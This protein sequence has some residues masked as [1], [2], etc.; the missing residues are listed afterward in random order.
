MVREIIKKSPQ[1]P[2][3][4]SQPKKSKA[5]IHLYETVRNKKKDKGKGKKER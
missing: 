1:K 4:G 5:V 2:S 3:L